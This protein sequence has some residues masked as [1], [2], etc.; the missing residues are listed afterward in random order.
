VRDHRSL[1]VSRGPHVRREASKRTVAA[2]R[3]AEQPKRPGHARWS[4]DAAQFYGVTRR[5]YKNLYRTL[6]ADET[7]NRF[8]RAEESRRGILVALSWG[9]LASIQMRQSGAAAEAILAADRGTRVMRD[10][11]LMAST[12]SQAELGDLEP[13]TPRALRK[14]A[15]RD[16]LHRWCE[17]L[18]VEW[19]IEL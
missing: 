2:L 9:R 10:A 6:A 16:D 18:L 4:R 11:Y 3:L 13:L 12:R 15:D 1:A 19:D 8:A 7:G 14:L 5:L 17:Q